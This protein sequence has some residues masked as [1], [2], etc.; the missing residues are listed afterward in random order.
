MTTPPALFLQGV[1]ALFYGKLS[2]DTRRACR[3][4]AR[5]QLP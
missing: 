3:P 1:K 2:H 5:Q 4:R